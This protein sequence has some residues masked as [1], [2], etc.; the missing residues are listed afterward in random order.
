MDDICVRAFRARTA[1]EACLLLYSSL[2]YLSV[3]PQPPPVLTPLEKARIEAENRE[4][5]RMIS[6]VPMVSVLL[7]VVPMFILS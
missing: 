7:F 1:P 3:L 6:D 5:E 2:I 4:Y